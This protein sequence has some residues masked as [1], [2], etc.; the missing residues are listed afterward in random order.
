MQ[1]RSHT[2]FICKLRSKLPH[3]SSLPDYLWPALQRAGFQAEASNLIL[4]QLPSC[5]VGVCI[6]LTWA[7]A[8]ETSLEEAEQLLQD[9][10][11][12]TTKVIDLE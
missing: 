4:W 9:Q 8:Q 1:G 12:S 6:A 2:D 5:V 11:L 10:Y 7:H 3:R